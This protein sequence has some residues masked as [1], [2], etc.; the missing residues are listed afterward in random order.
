MYNAPRS[1]TV[2]A[3]TDAVTW[4]LDRLTFRKVLKHASELHLKRYYLPY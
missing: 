3:V 1:A 2:C 4:V